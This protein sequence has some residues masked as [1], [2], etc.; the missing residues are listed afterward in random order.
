MIDLNYT[1]NQKFSIAG[2]YVDFKK[3][4]L[5]KPSYSTYFSNSGTLTSSG[6]SALI[7]LLEKFN[8]NKSKKIY[9]PG[10]ICE[11]IPKN[12]IDL[13]YKIEFYDIFLNGK[14][15]KII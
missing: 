1:V 3:Y 8:K 4:Q 7:L 14:N 9:L 6:R 11:T 2:Q 12:L 5:S 15:R 10:Y 13:G